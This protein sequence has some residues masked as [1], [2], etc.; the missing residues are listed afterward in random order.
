MHLT[1]DKQT[2][3]DLSIFGKAGSESI[4]Q[5]FNKTYTRGGALVLEELFRTPL[6]SDTLIN[7]R[8]DTIRFFQLGSIDFPLQGNRFEEVE[9]YLSNTDPRSRLSNQG[10]TMSDYKLISNGVMALTEILHSLLAFL[11]NIRNAASAG[12][13]GHDVER[14]LSLL[15]A[16]ELE[17]V[18]RLKLSTKPS[19]GE[20]VERDNVFRFGYKSELEQLLR[21]VYRLD[22]LTSIAQTAT[23]KALVFPRALKPDVYRLNIKDVYH[24]LVPDAIPNSL[25][26]TP[27]SNI[28][29]L[30]GAN[31]AGK[32][33]FMKSTGIAMYLAHLGFPVPAKEMEFSVCDG[34]YTTINLPD[35]LT[36]G[37]SHFYAEVLRV[38]N[39]AARLSAG[40]N[41]FV[42]FD[43]MFRGTN[44]KDAY[45]A[46]IAIMEAFAKNRHSLFIVSTHIIEAGNVLKDRCGNMIFRYLPTR[47]RH[48]TPEYTYKLEEGITEDRHGMVII[49]NEQVVDLI[50]SPKQ[51]RQPSGKFIADKQTLEDLNLLGKFRLQSVY[52]LFNR[53]QTRGGEK[54]LEEMFNHPLTDHESIN[55]R[56]ALFAFF[57]EH[58]VRFPVSRSQFESIESY[59]SGGGG[60]SLFRVAV[61]ITGKKISEAVYHNPGLL[62]LQAGLAIT[63]EALQTFSAFF[64]ELARK[65]SQG[66]Y[67][68]QLQKAR[69]IFQ[70]PKIR[71]MLDNYQPQLSL[72]QL[73]RIDH[74]IRHA[75][76]KEMRALLDI[77]Y[78]LD[79]CVSVAE[80][81]D[82]YGFSY[83]NALPREENRLDISGLRHPSIQNAVSNKLQ[84]AQQNN[85]LFLTGAN[86]AGKSTLMKS[87]GIAVYLAHMGFP[88]AADKMSIA[89]KDGLFSSINV[90]DDLNKGYS[91]F[92][93]EV[94]RV[95]AVAQAINAAQD[96]YVIFD[97]LFKGTNV[98]DAYDATFS[99][100]EAFSDNDNCFFIISTHIIEVGTALQ[101]RRSNIRFSF[102]P[103][104]MQGSTPKY[105]YKLEKGITS[106][107]HGMMIIRNE[108]ILEML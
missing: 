81:A 49:N 20:V 46:T 91:H 69:Q 67:G 66:V 18:F 45:E 14:M 60:A 104:V 76:A 57:Q 56:S 95:K 40:K 53:V 19:S 87:F 65:D 88:V 73:I 59:L 98:K 99:V 21:L 39:I 100:T 3:D 71:T 22:A 5:L 80:A 55:R 102:L 6:S 101:E 75:L 62:Q 29:F 15:K 93:A 12:P 31:M 35:N 52:G 106:D 74:L 13:Y 30:T 27:D 94:L 97:E 61:S 64:E 58:K 44:V 17:P 83:A 37:A 25:L 38:K 32:S 23:K 70:H 84:L 79:V 28:V 89:V 82:L 68:P 16:K 85:V 8:I 107:R 7:E 33:T 50:K 63:V 9:R 78:H 90:A 86:M 43:E 36:I 77:I 34:I 2:L 103:T 92:Y 48:N 108:G 51:A 47:M 26:M 1:T 11:Q 24:P 10:F 42:I 96:L 54:L 72:P 41:L 105:T 4:Y